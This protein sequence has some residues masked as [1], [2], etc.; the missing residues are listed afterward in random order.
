MNDNSSLYSSIMERL[1]IENPSDIPTVCKDYD[2]ISFSDENSP[3]SIW[4]YRVLM[5]A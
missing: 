4:T 2:N 1:F 5:Q 3:F